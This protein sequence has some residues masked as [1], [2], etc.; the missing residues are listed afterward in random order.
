M[1]GLSLHGTDDSKK[2]ISDAGAK[3]R[4]PWQRSASRFN[5]LDGL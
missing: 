5:P 3:G 4:T 2:K 1:I